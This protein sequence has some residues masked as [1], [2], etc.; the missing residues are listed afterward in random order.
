MASDLDKVAE[1]AWRTPFR[2][3]AAP[4]HRNGA[5]LRDT[6]RVFYGTD[7]A[8]IRS[9]LTRRGVAYVL[10]CERDPMMDGAFTRRLLDR[11][12]PDW[13]QE[14]APPAEDA[15]AGARLFRIR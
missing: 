4:Y 6:L 3:V 2:F 10:V 12:A 9:I 15:A 8:E 14:I 1:L 7:E 13:M 5:A 11:A